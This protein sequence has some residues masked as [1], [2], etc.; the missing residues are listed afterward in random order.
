MRFDIL[1]YGNNKGDAQF[2]ADMVAQKSI[3]HHHKGMGNSILENQSEE[4]SRASRRAISPIL[5]V[6]TRLYPTNDKRGLYLVNS[7]IEDYRKDFK[8][9]MKHIRECVKSFTDDE[10]FNA[11]TEV[12]GRYDARTKAKGRKTQF[13]A[14]L[15]RHSCNEASGFHQGIF[16]RL[17]D[18]KGNEIWCP[19]QL[20]PLLNPSREALSYLDNGDDP[21]WGE[22]IWNKPLWAVPF[23]RVMEPPIV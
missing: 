23:Q 4:E 19:D 6:S 11:R 14:H 7:I 17:Y 13:P 3:E 18:L 5:Q 16:A 20:M 1:V 22:H 9:S 21:Y 15:F 2:N 12:I 10:L 8:K